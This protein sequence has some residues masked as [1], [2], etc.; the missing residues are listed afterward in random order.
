MRLALALG[1]SVNQPMPVAAAANEVFKTAIAMVRRNLCRL[2]AAASS[3]FYFISVHG[4]EH[5]KM[6]NS[7]LL[8][9]SL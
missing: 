6:F 1:D 8:D 5:L 2:V 3:P 9:R 4:V 7:K